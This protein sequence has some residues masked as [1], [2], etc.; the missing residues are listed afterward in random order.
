MR[1]GFSIVF[2]FIMMLSGARVT[3]ATHFCGGHIAAKTVSLTGKLASCGMENGEG[4]CSSTESSIK[5]HCCE[6]HIRCLCLPDNFTPGENAGADF[7]PDVTLISFLPVVQ[8]HFS[9][10]N[11][12]CNFTDTGPPGPFSPTS[13]KLMSICTFR[14]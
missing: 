10:E 8:V 9:S 1:K 13:V 14:I 5:S 11:S 2:A 7:F 6:D 12:S 3:I 4:L